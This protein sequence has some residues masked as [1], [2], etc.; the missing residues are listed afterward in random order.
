MSRSGRAQALAA[1]FEEAN[2]ELINVLG[3]LPDKSW[4]R[5]CPDEGWPVGVTAHH[6]AVAYPEHIRILQA[7]A[8]ERPLPPL[9]WSDLEQ[10]NS[11]HAERHASC[12]RPETVDLLVR[13]AQAVTATLQHLSDDQL[14]R[15]GSLIADFGRLSVRQWVEQVVIGHVRVHLGSIRAAA[16]TPG[17]S[18]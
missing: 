4:H 12:T 10:L 6:I 18:R 11:R 1:R 9:T 17:L 2:Q 14:E 16:G 8:E 13:N 5:L 7:I 3:R 15:R